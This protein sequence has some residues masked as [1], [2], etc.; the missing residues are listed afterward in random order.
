M[1]FFQ[2]LKRLIDVY[3]YFIRLFQAA[4]GLFNNEVILGLMAPK[5]G[6]PSQMAAIMGTPINIPGVEKDETAEEQ[7]PLVPSKFVKTLPRS[8]FILYNMIDS[9][10]LSTCFEVGYK[11][12]TMV[13]FVLKLGVGKEDEKAM[14]KALGN[15]KGAEAEKKRKAAEEAAKADA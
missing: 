9:L 1:K 3:P 2:M 15:T 10:P 5:D 4:Q 7:E 11:M 14:D 6:S 13:R 12:S 8:F